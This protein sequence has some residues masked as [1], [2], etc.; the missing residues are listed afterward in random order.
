MRHTLL[1]ASLAL[2]L[3]VCAQPSHAALPPGISGSWFNPAQSG[4]GLSIQILEDDRALAFWFV[5]DRA[6]NPVHLYIEGAVQGTTISGTAWA[7]RGMEFGSFDP[8]DH[9]LDRWGSVEIDFSDC[10]HAALQWNASGPAGSGYGDGTTALQRLTRIDSTQCVLHAPEQFPIGVY[11][12]TFTADYTNAWPAS[13]HALV[14][15][16]GRVWAAYEVV[17]YSTSFSHGGLG[18][19]ITGTVVDWWPGTAAIEATLRTNEWMRDIIPSSHDVA[20]RRPAAPFDLVLHHGASDATI[21]GTR[22]GIEVALSQDGSSAVLDPVQTAAEMAGTYAFVAAAPYV[23]PFQHTVSIDPQ[24][25]LCIGWEEA[26]CAMFTG[27]I[28]PTATPGVQA[29]AIAHATNPQIRYEGQAWRQQGGGEPA[30]LVMVA[31]DEDH[32]FG[33]VAELVSGTGEIR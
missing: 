7:G 30:T 18:A 16:D 33:I 15:A 22:G 24:G 29:F 10:S 12:G 14:T 26:P 31:T 28:A 27:M 2:A 5:Y 9:T 21:R 19:V 23:G 6:G 1:P 8:A 11:S 32:G 25:G 20:P 13:L 3:G 17:G 4:H